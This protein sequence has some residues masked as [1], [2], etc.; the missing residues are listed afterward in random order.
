M[1][2]CLS[3]VLFLAGLTACQYSQAL[4]APPGPNLLVNPSFENGLENWTINDTTSVAWVQDYEFRPPNDDGVGAAV[5]FTDSGIS[6]CVPALGGTEYVASLWAFG[7]CSD[8]STFLRIDWFV[9][10]NCSTSADSTFATIVGKSNTWVLTSVVQQ[11]M[12]AA[13]S[14]RFTLAR[15]ATCE[16]AIV[17]DDVEF[18]TDT[19]FAG[20]FE[21]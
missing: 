5:L 11:T 8:S 17:L 15:T 19:I 13:N 18:I 21:D 20:T 1:R 2:A 3:S 6:Q 4:Q 16:E 14:A 10:E 7:G 12:T 9:D